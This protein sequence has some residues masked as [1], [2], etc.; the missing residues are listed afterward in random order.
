MN[1]KKEN[2]NVMD[3]VGSNKKHL[4]SNPTQMKYNVV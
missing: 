2:E 3:S 1:K 4:M